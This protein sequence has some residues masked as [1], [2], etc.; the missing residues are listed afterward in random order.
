[1]V[2]LSRCRPAGSRIEVGCRRRARRRRPRSV[3]CRRRWTPRRGRP[4]GG[5]GGCGVR[6]R[7]RRRSGRRR[8]AG[9]CSVRCRGC[10][11]GG[12]VDAFGA[13]VSEHAVAPASSA[14]CCGGCVAAGASHA[15]RGPAASGS[16]V[17]RSPRWLR[18]R[19]RRARWVAAV[20]R[21]RPRPRRRRLPVPGCGCRWRRWRRSPCSFLVCVWCRPC[22]G[23]CPLS[24]CSSARAEPRR[25]SRPLGRRLRRSAHARF[26]WR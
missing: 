21:P 25:G 11:L 3:A 1:M 15:R 20:W 7:S 16:R 19:F 14:V 18:S 24:P 2:R 17:L 22:R 13:P 26:S 10:A 12:D 8:G 23:R 4:L 6:A 9:R 5:A